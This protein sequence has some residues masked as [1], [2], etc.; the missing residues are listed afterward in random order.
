L[1]TK[2][3]FQN[4]HLTQL[5]EHVCF[6]SRDNRLKDEPPPRDGVRFPH[7]ERKML[8]RALILAT[9]MLWIGCFA[10]V[11]ALAQENLEAGKSPSQIFAGTCNACHKSPRGLL[12]T[13]AAGSLPSFLRQHY[14]TSPQMANVLAA[15]LVS[16]G[17]NDPRAA[18]ASP[19][20]A[21]E[22]PKDGTKEAKQETKPVEQLDRFG[23]KQHPTTAPQEAAAPAGEKPPDMQQPAQA[24]GKLSPKQKL[25]KPGKPAE[26]L[27]REE[28]TAATEPPKGESANVE[29]G[30]PEGNA[31]V[32]TADSPSES[33]KMEPPKDAPT[34]GPDP[35]PP[36]TPAPSASPAANTAAPPAA[37]TPPPSRLPPTVSAADA[38]PNNSASE[39]LPVMSLPPAPAVTASAPSLPPVPPAGPPAPPI[40]Q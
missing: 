6:H 17:A 3:I 2:R 18:A 4:T 35:V 39:P 1:S 14:T 24:A 37:A 25:S 28:P 8:S 31:P 33:A 16:N 40:S 9:V 34:L 5:R 27:P 32:P 22:G 36:V 38:T 19:K 10:S 15:Y 13:V 23:R 30:K 7:L 26:E 11:R 21:K 20:G 12:R 29:P